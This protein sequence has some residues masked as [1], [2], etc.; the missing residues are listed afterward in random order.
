[1]ELEKNKTDVLKFNCIKN[2]KEEVKLPEKIDDNYVKGIAKTEPNSTSTSSEYSCALCGQDVSKSDLSELSEEQF[3]RLSFDEETIFSQE[4]KS[5]FR[6][7]EILETGKRFGLQLELLHKAGIDGKGVNVAVLDT[8][9]NV[10]N[11]EMKDKYGKSKCIIY[12]NETAHNKTMDFMHGKTVT[13]LLCGTN[14]GVAPNL[15]LYFFAINNGNKEHYIHAFEKIK[16]LNKEGHNI[17]IISMSSP[18]EKECNEQYTKEFRD[19]NCELLDSTNWLKSGYMYYNRNNYL[20]INEPQ[21]FELE[22]SIEEFDNIINETS[23]RTI[24]NGGNPD[25]VKAILGGIPFEDKLFI[26]CGGRTYPQVGENNYKYSAYSSAS[27]TIP[28]VAGLFALAKQLNPLLTFEEFTQISRETCYR[29]EQGYRVVN[30]EGIARQIN[31]INKEK[32]QNDDRYKDIYS[33]SQ[34]LIDALDEVI[35]KQEVNTQKLGQETMQEQN[36][37]SYIK[38]TE[39]EIEKSDLKQNKNYLGR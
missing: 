30:P 24:E 2:Y 3:I 6:P 15:N 14:V 22:L 11:I 13:A 18:V 37:T 4:Q 32:A 25:Y 9:F 7:N 16:K 26:P 39:Q 12:D 28:Q 36:D 38:E 33:E 17:S 20:N 35:K 5:K 31:E 10:D 23:K 1:M 19:N 29:N 27:W 8:N 21:N 34:K